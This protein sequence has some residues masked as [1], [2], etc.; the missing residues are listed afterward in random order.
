MEE[1]TIGNLIKEYVDASEYNVK[2]FAQAISVSRAN[3]YDI[4][5][6]NTMD[7]ELLARISKVLHHNF[8]SDVASNMNLANPVNETEKESLRRKSIMQFQD[9]V[10]RI[11]KSMNIEAQIFLGLDASITDEMFVPDYLIS[12]Y[13]ITLT[14]G[15]TFEEKYNVS[16]SPYFKFKYFSDNKG[17]NFSIMSNIISK[18][19][20]CDLALIYRTEEEW[21]GLLEFIFST[22]KNEYN[23]VTKNEIK[24]LQSEI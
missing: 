22:I 17:H 9:V 14:Y 12:P 19:Q 7:I 11:L 18:T 3:V 6:R 16:N 13:F 20:S 10:P 5:N 8:F 4:F 24:K 23:D 15:M 1:K 21:R 2:E